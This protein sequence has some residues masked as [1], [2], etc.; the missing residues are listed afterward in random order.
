MGV[1]ALCFGALWS[2]PWLN[3]EDICQIGVYAAYNIF[4]IPE[5]AL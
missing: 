1:G 3:T 5:Q 4:Y 2:R